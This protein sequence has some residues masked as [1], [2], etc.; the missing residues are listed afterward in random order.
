MPVKDTDTTPYWTTSSTFPP[1]TRLA[2]DAEADVVV[3]GAGLTG[4][5][6]AYLLV[7]GGKRVVVLERERCAMADTGHTSAHLTMVTDT[8]ISERTWDCPCHGSRF[9]PTGEVS[10]GPAE[11][12]LAKAD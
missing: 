10:S 4:L 6:T 2:E 7:K 9:K 1:F 12:P 8:R 11:T 5:T 3:V